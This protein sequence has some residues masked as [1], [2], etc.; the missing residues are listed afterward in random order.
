MSEILITYFS[1]IEYN[2]GWTDHDGSDPTDKDVPAA[3]QKTQ[4]E[5]IVFVSLKIVIKVFI[6][7][8]FILKLILVLVVETF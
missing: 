7:E 3:D 8:V 4:E 1:D 2:H 5:I 6:S